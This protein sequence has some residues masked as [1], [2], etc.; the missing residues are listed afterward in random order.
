M[1]N[2]TNTVGVYIGRNTPDPTRI[3]EH[4]YVL[5]LENYKDYDSQSGYG[6][7]S[8]FL[9]PKNEHP[10]KEVLEEALLWEK[11]LREKER[12]SIDFLNSTKP[13]LVA[14][15]FSRTGNDTGAEMTLYL[16]A[17]V[18]REMP[19]FRQWGEYYRVTSD[20]KCNLIV[21]KVALKDIILFYLKN[22]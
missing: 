18:D 9:R 2:F 10:A 12:F 4:Q 19:Y 17:F 6:H 5:N 14:E 13:S 8:H 22:I 3:G 21:E 1:I 15:I 20:G 7:Y 16:P 11:E